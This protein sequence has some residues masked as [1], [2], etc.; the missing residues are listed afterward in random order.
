VTT[1]ESRP[2]TPATS[3]VTLPANNNSDAFDTVASLH[4]IPY[5]GDEAIRWLAAFQDEAV[6]GIA[7]QIFRSLTLFRV[8]DQEQARAELADSAHRIDRLE[9]EIESIPLLLRR[10]HHSALAYQHYLDGDLEAAGNSLSDAQQAL[11]AVIA[12]HF[13]LLPL[14]IHSIDFRIQRARMARREN[15][16]SDVQYHLDI[17]RRTYRGDHPFCQLPSGPVAL[18]DLRGFYLSLPVESLEQMPEKTRFIMDD[19]YRHD[20]LIDRLEEQVFTLPDF[21]IP[22]A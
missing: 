1:S 7:K 11:E 9:A 15:S 20:D 6:A 10:W 16:W 13:F 19:S 21:V 2:A 14:A 4:H 18:G 5:C 17:V 8:H 3:T 22:Y 12:R